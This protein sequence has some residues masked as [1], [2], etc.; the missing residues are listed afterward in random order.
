MD[1]NEVIADAKRAK[2]LGDLDLEL[3]L[4]RKADS[5]QPQVAQPTRSDIGGL[6]LRPFGIDTGVTMPQSLSE[7]LAG[8]GRRMTEIGTL[9]NNQ[10]QPQ[11][12]RLLDDSGYAM[13]GGIGTDIGAMAL[14]GGLLR[15]ASAV[16]KVGKAL[17]WAV[18]WS[19]SRAACSAGSSGSA[20]P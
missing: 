1:Y 12:D 16:P 18:F 10:V 13:A 7:G 8:M 17:Q 9:G 6:E 2:E 15:G 4:L 19:A 14:G 3:A 20:N 11:A 5:M